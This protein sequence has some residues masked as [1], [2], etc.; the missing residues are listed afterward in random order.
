MENDNSNEIEEPRRSRRTSRSFWFPIAL[1]TL[2]VIF[3]L[4][5][6]GNFTFENWWA[7]F[8]LIPAFSAFG[9]A[10]NLWRRSGRFSVGVWSTF[11]GGIFPLAVALIFLF[12]LPWE[13]YWPVFIILAG[14]GMMNSGLIGSQ[15]KDIRIPKALRYH[16]AWSFFIGLGGTL[17]GLSFLGLNL[18][19]FETVPFINAQNWWAVFIIVAAV[20]GLVTAVLLLAGGHSTILAVLNLAGAALV[21]FVGYIALNRLDWDLINM[22]FPVLLILVGIGVIVGFGSKRVRGE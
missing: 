15:P 12:D 10:F 3:L 17:L 20:G 7:L 13:E 6:I 8:I 1:I 18:N 2:G 14:I 22:A 21:G 16:Q 19:W 9:T 4:Q 5:R 11:F